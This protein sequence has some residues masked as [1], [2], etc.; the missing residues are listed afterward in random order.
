MVRAQ[1][2]VRP[3]DDANELVEITWLL[4]DA[5][6][7]ERGRLTQQN[8]VARGRLDHRWGVVAKLAAAAAAPEIADLMRRFSP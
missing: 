6:G 1:V 4:H 5:D 7:R 3:M 8:R 2:S